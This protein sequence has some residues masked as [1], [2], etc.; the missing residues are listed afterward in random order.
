MISNKEDERYLDDSAGQTE[1]YGHIYFESRDRQKELWKSGLP[2]N[3]E[4]LPCGENY[5][6]TDVQE[7]GRTPAALKFIKIGW[8]LIGIAATVEMAGFPLPKVGDKPFALAL[9]MSGVLF[10]TVGYFAHFVAFAFL[11]AGFYAICDAGTTP[12]GFHLD[13]VPVRIYLSALG[14]A[15][16]GGAIDRVF[17]EKK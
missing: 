14:L 2:E 8:C 16:M 3:T 12:T 15:A 17:G 4:R 11:V 1:D 9:A 7:T 10:L 13:A 6:E 5:Y